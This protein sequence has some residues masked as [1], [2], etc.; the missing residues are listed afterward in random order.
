MRKCILFFSALLMLTACGNNQQNQKQ[1]HEQT[2]TSEYRF[3]Y[4][5]VKGDDGDYHSIIV[6]G[7]E[8]DGNCTFEC[9][10]DLVASVSEESAADTR[11]ITDTE[12]INFDGQPDLQ[13]FLWHT[14]VGQVIKSYAA[15]TI[16]PQHQIEE[17]KQWTDLCN[18]EIHPDSKTV[19]ANYR[20]DSNERTFETYQWNDDNT[21][22]LIDTRKEPLFTE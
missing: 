17:V 12:D 9:S 3:E 8:G 21:L 15:Y 16:T 6:K 1:E 22:E 7:Y 18:P 5:L 20:S 13:I 10:H 2:D 11:W 14:V 19:T 4:Q